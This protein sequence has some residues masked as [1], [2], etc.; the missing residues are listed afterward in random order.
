MWT[1][2]ILFA[3]G[4]VLIVSEF[5][6]PGGVLGVLGGILLIISCVLGWIWY[7]SYGIFIVLGEVVGLCIGVVLGLY[8]MANT[9]L[10]GGLYMNESQQKELGYS[11]PHEDPALVGQEGTVYSPLRP[12][13]TVMV[14]GRRVNA[15]SDGTYIDKGTPIRVIEVEGHRVVVEPTEFKPSEQAS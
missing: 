3:V 5:I 11:S 9:R 12:A 7:P 8:L 1:V 2:V 6:V 15:V 10:A 14:D 13:G 4:I